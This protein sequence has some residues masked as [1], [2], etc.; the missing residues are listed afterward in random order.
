MVNIAVYPPRFLSVVIPA[1]RKAPVIQTQLRQ[2]I[3]ILKECAPSHEIILVIDGDVDGTVQEVRKL[4][5]PSLRLFSLPNNSGK[6]EAVKFGFRQARG[7]YIVYLD[8]GDDLD[9]RDLP[10][11]LAEMAIHDADI[12]IG[13]KRHPLS[14]VSYPL[15]RRFYSWAYQL[16]NRVLFRMNIRDSQVGFKLLHR[17]VVEAVLPHLRTSRFAFDLELLVLADRLGYSRI[18]E[19]PI[20][21]HYSFSSNVNWREALRTLGD[22][23][24]IFFRHRFTL[25]H[26]AY[27]APSEKSSASISSGRGVRK[28]LKFNQRPNKP[29]PTFPYIRGGSAVGKIARPHYL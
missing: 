23:L 17:K 16:L 7:D 24:A 13:S 26:H 5:I 15:R 18:V 19:A 28:R 22:T 21:L 14:R 6:G 27:P 25:P 10:V 11:M 8:A 29:S 1:Y 3:K 20:T 12:V 4:N 9:V 2:L